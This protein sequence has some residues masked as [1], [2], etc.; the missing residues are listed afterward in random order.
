MSILLIDARTRPSAATTHPSDAV[1]PGHPPKT[2][3]SR[4]KSPGP[5]PRLS[6]LTHSV[7]SHAQYTTL[8]VMAGLDPAI[9]V[10]PS[11]PMI[12]VRRGVATRHKAGHDEKRIYR[13]QR[14]LSAARPANWATGPNSSSMRISWLYLANRSERD[15]EPV[16]I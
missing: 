7:V 4:S 12:E 8:L 1:T 13:L 9:H 6:A 15:N 16:L 11:S 3:T 14:R 2:L 10:V 5:S